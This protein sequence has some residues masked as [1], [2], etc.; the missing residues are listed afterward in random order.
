MAH[1][2]GLVP[3]K[4][5]KNLWRVVVKQIPGETTSKGVGV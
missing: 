2:E 5:K 1:K 4:K 3:L